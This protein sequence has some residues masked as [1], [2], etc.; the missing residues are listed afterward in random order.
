MSDLL[1][2]GGRVASVETG[3]L[4]AADVVVEG[5]RITG[6]VPPGGAATAEP[7]EEIDAR[8]AV[9][10][11]G[12]VDAHMHVESSFLTPGPF[13]WLS[14]ARGT[15]TVLADPHEIGNVGGEAAVRWMVAEGRRQPQTML[16]AVPSCVPSLPELETAGA[17][18]DV[19]AIARLAQEPE[20]VALG[21]VMD[22]RAVV[23]GNPRMVRTVAAARRA[24]LILDGHCPGLSGDELARYLDLGIDSDHTKNTTP[25]AL[26][27]ARMGM[28]LMLQEKCLVPDLIAAL[29]AF[30]LPP[31]VC[32][33]TDD[34]AAD[35]IGDHGHLDHI[36]RTAVRAGMAPAT[37]LRALT[38][39]PARR[40]RLEDRGM[41]APGRR[42]DLV[43]VADLE[44]LEPLAAV[45]GGRVVGREGRPIS[46]E[47]QVGPHPFA[48]SVHLPPLDREALAWPMA[49][50]DGPV[51]LRAIRV[52]AIDTSTVPDVV[53]ATIRDGR[54]E[55]PEGVI[56]LA[57]L[58]RHGRT[59]DRAFAPVV[60][61]HLADGAVATTYAHDSHNL[62]VLGTSTAAM[63]A[64]AQA[65]VGV[66]GGIAVAR[67]E[68]VVALLPLPVAGVM[69]DRPVAEVADGARAVRRELAAWGYHHTNPL[70]S[71]STLSLP[72]SPALKLTDR[73]LV[74]VLA[75]EPVAATV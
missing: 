30:D 57:C 58:H 1:V 65:V 21:E 62:V 50:P 73:G 26:E 6:V 49:A 14:Q 34:I 43:L 68:Q 53:E 60:G 45:A 5:D 31:S 25:V 56:R 39:T 75:R 52:N 12:F 7:A 71:I 10:V 54:V 13:A 2:R 19:D 66:G 72:V 51:R 9:V 22:Y 4:F 40:L 20:I 24:G 41:V 33:V 48:D 42:A 63:A 11:P 17:E 74:D 32:L 29:A 67:G 35:A 3:E 27:K 18:L 61:A 38:L 59:G 47:P 23:A 70:M 69:S 64:A 44:S 15:T 46:E 8:G 55:L 28:T 37:V 36:G 16:F